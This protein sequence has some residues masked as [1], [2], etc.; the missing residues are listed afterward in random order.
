[1]TKKPE[2]VAFIPI[3][4]N[5]DQAS[6]PIGYVDLADERCVLKLNPKQKV[7]LEDINSGKSVFAPSYIVSKEKDGIVIEVVL[8]SFS[9]ITRKD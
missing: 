3:L 6:N 5:F 4:L 7:L 2:Q 8:D 9:L 1:M